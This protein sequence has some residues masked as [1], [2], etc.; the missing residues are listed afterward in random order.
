MKKNVSKIRLAVFLLAVMAMVLGASMTVY[1]GYVDCTVN[2][3][4]PIRDQPNNTSGIQTNLKKG[5]VVKANLNYKKNKYCRVRYQNFYGWFLAGWLTPKGSTNTRT[6]VQQTTLRK[7]AS[8]NDQMIMNIPKG[9]SVN[10]L[11]VTNNSWYK[12]TYRNQTGYIPPEALDGGRISPAATNRQPETYYT[13]NKKGMKT[14]LHSQPVIGNQ[15]VTISL[16]PNTPVTL[17]DVVPARQSNGNV[18]Q[19]GYVQYRNIYGYIAMSELR[20]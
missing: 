6:T 4:A 20:K 16:E 10:V 18:I 13:T 1:A 2:R 9:K 19:F 5:D 11:G 8:Y 12:V 17:W 14:R 7:G 15:C 3:A